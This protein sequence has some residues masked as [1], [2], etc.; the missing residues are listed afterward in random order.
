[1][2]EVRRLPDDSLARFVH[3]P[4][5]LA[6]EQYLSQRSH[7]P[8]LQTARRHAGRR[9]LVPIQLRRFRR[10]QGGHDRPERL[11]H[12]LRIVQL[13][14]RFE[15]LR[16]SNR[17][18]Q[19]HQVG[20]RQRYCLD[21]RRRFPGDIQRVAARLADQVAQH[22]PLQRPKPAHHLRHCLFHRRPPLDPRRDL[23][24]RLDQDVVGQA[25][26]KVILVILLLRRRQQIHR[27]EFPQ[28]KVLPILRR[29]PE[30]L[31]VYLA[32]FR[33]IGLEVQLAGPHS[34]RQ[35]LYPVLLFRRDEKLGDLPR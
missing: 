12:S 18:P 35:R 32:H 17:L 2:R 19:L 30:N 27:L 26:A 3:A 33:L 5:T 23:L 10:R 20:S 21:L 28:Y 6:R 4:Q 29:R 22:R 25:P 14:Q 34:P 24:A 31:F 15:Q 7:H 16:L 13:E 1:M 9:P 11:L 8:A